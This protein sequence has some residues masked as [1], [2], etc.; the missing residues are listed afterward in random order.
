MTNFVLP[1]IGIILLFLVVGVVAIFNRLIRL[2]NQ[3]DEAFSGMDVQMKMRYDLIPNLVET[4][5]GYA[6][7]ESE[8]LEAVIAARNMASRTQNVEEAMV[9]ENQLTHALRSLFAVAESYPDLKANANFID[10]QN[11]L[12]KIENDIAKSR[13]YYNGTVKQFNNVVAVFPNNLI[14]G[15]LGFT[16]QPYYTLDSEAER[17]V[18]EVRF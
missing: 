8:T 12:Q 17:S 7:H 13:L 11:S 5:K 16:K 1:I 14:A 15:I 3:V 9:A 4:V 2:K 6:S 10:L 18:P